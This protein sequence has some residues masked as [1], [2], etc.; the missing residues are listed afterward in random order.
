MEREDCNYH[1]LG[2]IHVLL[3]RSLQDVIESSDILHV[4]G[5]KA[6]PGSAKVEPLGGEI[7]SN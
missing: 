1:S 2:K 3:L 5:L 7:F 6:L 4:Q